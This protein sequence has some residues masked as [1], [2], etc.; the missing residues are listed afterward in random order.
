VHAP[1]D[2]DGHGSHTSVSGASPHVRIYVQKVC[3]RRGCPTSAIVSAIRAAADYPGM[4]A[5][6]LSILRVRPSA[7]FP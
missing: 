5:M 3:G 6:N 4:V 2:D 1:T 7:S